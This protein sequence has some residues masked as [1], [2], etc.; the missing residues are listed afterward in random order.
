MMKKR[1]LRLTSLLLVFA[2]L[3]AEL[4]LAALAYT[5][6]S[7][8]PIPAEVERT[9]DGQGGYEAMV[10]NTER[11]GGGEPLTSEE[12]D[13]AAPAGAALDGSR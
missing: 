12:P 3:F 6:D 8:E 2:L 5:H 1:N 11:L 9:A 4:P 13:Y 10:E 7:T